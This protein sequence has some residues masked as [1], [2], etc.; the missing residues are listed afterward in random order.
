MPPD[1]EE[2]RRWLRK[3]EHDRIAAEAAL[4]LVPPITDIA[5]FHCQQAIE[6]TLKA[7]LFWRG[8]EFERTHDLR[9]LITYCADQDSAFGDFM[10][11]VA[12]LTHYAVRYRYPGPADPTVDE[13][14]QALEVASEVRVFALARLP[15]ECQS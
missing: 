1:I 10:S 6:K 8:V 9:E 2:L 5:A 7:Y 14:R 12:P 3:A 13:V 4:G 15:A 11:K